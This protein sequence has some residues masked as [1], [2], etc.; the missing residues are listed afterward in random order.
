MIGRF[1]FI[2]PVPLLISN[3]LL[4]PSQ[5]V[6]KDSNST[7]CAGAYEQCGGSGYNGKTCCVAGYE[8]T[9]DNE[10]FSGC[11]PIPVCTNPAYGQC[12]GVDSDGVSWLEKHD[13][14]CPDGFNC[15]YASPYYSQCLEAHSVAPKDE[16]A[17]EIKEGQSA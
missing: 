12:G 17:E 3:E 11:T 9:E 13:A 10:Y 16:A 4:L 5:C 7:D 6:E 1:I 15:A 8:C 14:C 2:L